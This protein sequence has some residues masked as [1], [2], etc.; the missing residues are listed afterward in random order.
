MTI[1]KTTIVSPHSREFNDLT[2]QI[3]RIAKQLALPDT[4]GAEE[5]AAFEDKGFL[6]SDYGLEKYRELGAKGR[7]YAI[8]SATKVVA[9]SAIYRP[10]D[11]ADKDDLGTEFVRQNYGAVPMM[12]QVGV[13]PSYKGTGLRN[14]AT[15]LHDDFARRYPTMCVYGAVVAEPPNRRSEAFHLS[16]GFVDCATLD[17]HSDGRR[18]VI[19]MRPSLIERELRRISSFMPRRA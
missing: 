17:D 7:L 11:P 2:L 3:S 12:K 15:M 9:F 5:Q 4:I 14:A 18:R 8:L 6:V 13:D 10:E 19:G 1:L 16:L